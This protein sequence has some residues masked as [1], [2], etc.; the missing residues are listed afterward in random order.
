M[1]D[2]EQALIDW[3]PEKVGVPCYADVPAERPK[4]FITVE[5]TGGSSSFAKDEPLLAV[6]AWAESR[7]SASELAARIREVLV[8]SALEIVQVCRCE[9][10]STYNFPD[11]DSRMS[12][13]QLDVEMVTRL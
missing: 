12:R 9:V 8:Y 4:A 6:Q 5:R 1:F 2:V 11:P 7:L 13:Y 10:T 3:L